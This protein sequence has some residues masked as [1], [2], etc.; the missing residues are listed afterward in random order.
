MLQR[1]DGKT[2]VT[3]NGDPMYRFTEDQSGM[4]KGDG[5]KDAFAGQE[6]TWHV[7]TAGNEPSAPPSTSGSG[8]GGSGY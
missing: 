7:V 3:F 1:P 6:F 8:S 2:Q 5:V 4:L